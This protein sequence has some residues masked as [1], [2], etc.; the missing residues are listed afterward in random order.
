MPWRGAAAK[1]VGEFT[2]EFLRPIANSFVAHVNAASGEHFLDHSQAERKPEME[3]LGIAD[4]LGG[5]AI[6]T[7]RGVTRRVHVPRVRPV[8][9]FL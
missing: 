5:E 4:H 1:A 2:T 6:T 8:G 7:I 3:P 9:A